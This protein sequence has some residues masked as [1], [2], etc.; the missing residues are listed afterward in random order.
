[1][2]P[3]MQKCKIPRKYSEN[4]HSIKVKSFNVKNKFTDTI[5]ILLTLAFSL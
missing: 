2:F 3:K 4:T 1:M 5:I